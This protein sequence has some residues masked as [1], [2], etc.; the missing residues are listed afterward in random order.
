MGKA[1]RREE[2]VSCAV[3][4]RSRS[5]GRGGRESELAR[6]LCPFASTSRLMDQTTNVPIWCS[7]GRT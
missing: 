7:L 6:E 3:G 2:R 5:S 1:L 4:D